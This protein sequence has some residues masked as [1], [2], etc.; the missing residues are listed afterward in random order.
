VG[1]AG[2]P[3]PPLSH[4]RHSLGAKSSRL[5]HPPAC[6]PPPPAGLSA[7]GL[8]CQ[9]GIQ[10]AFLLGAPGLRAVVPFLRVL[11][12]PRADSLADALLVG[13]HASTPACQPAC[14]PAPSLQRVMLLPLQCLVACST[15]RH[16]R[17]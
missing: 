5:A 8:L 3:E 9:L 12:F 7:L 6:S 4:G 13:P 1:A 11:G 16:H 17:C 15:S 14:Q 2:L 10:A